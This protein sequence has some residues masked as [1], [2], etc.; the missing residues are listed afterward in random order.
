MERAL[1]LI[2]VERGHDPRDFTLIC[3]GGAGGL[4]AADLARSLDLRAVVVPMHP[5]AFSALG[6][7]FSDIVKEVS[8]SVLRIVPAT[9]HDDRSFDRPIRA[10]LEW[11]ERRF[12]SIKKKGLAE[13]KR[14]G[15]DVENAIIERRL[16]CRYAG[17]AYELSIPFARDF[18]NQ[19]HADHER[20]YG[21]AQPAQLLEIVSLQIRMTLPTPKPAHGPLGIRSKF[22]IQRA[23][24]KTKNVWFNGKP[25]R[26]TFYEREK[27]APGM[28]IRGPAIVVEYSSTTVIPPDFV[29]TVDD[30]LNLVLKRHAH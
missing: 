6:I 25:M 15:F 19:F 2:S 27:L 17:Q 29:C 3:F 30:H 5:G 22:G 1:R 20:A 8:H 18:Q 11:L 12:D 10:F 7:L 16:A 13:F 28:R 24:V 14:E 26:T 9:L 23:A 4:H 21:Y